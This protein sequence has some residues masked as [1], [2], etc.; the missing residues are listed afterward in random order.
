MFGN[1]ILKNYCCFL[2][3]KSLL[4]YLPNKLGHTHDNSIDGH[5]QI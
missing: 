4:M 3:E 5:K 1:F 2:Q